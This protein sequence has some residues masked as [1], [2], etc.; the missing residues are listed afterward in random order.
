MSDTD[1]LL[2]EYV[3][4]ELD[5]GVV[6]EAE[7]L[8]ATD[9]RARRKVE[10]FRETASLLR[11]ACSES[12]YLGDEG[13]LPSATVPLRRT[14]RRYGWALAASIAAGVIIGVSGSAMWVGLPRTE[15]ALL[16]D[17]IAEYHPIY[18]RESKHLVE[19]QADRA[20]DLAAWL[21]MSAERRFT[22]PD[23]TVAGLHFAGGRM[24]VANGR[25]VAQLMYTRDRGLPVGLCLTRMDGKPAAV[26]I[27]TRGA[28]RL[29]SWEDDGYAFVIAGEIDEATARDLAGKVRAQ[30][31]S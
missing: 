25:P 28:L 5:I 12:F 30:L 17:E 31:N 24:L 16:I 18:S 19:I 4:G 15:R 2:L 13:V 26:S 3:D 21:G 20:D 7:R 1:S 29:A 6:Q 8:I 14:R 23:L 11:A 22:V 9:A 27:D 10:M